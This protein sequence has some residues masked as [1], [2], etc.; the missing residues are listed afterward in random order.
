MTPEAHVVFQLAE[1]EAKSIIDWRSGWPDALAYVLGLAAAWFGG[2]QA[3][4]LIWSLWLSSLVIGYALIVWSI[5]QPIAVFSIIAWRSRND[6]GGPGLRDIVTF[7]S[8]M[9]GVGLFLVAFFTVHF[10]GFHYVY[11]AILINIFPIVAPGIPHPDWLEKATYLEIVRRYWIFLP[12]AFL[13]H[14][15]AFIR[16]TFLLD[17]NE[18]V[19]SWKEPGENNE[20]FKEPYKNVLRLHA[21]IGFVAAAHIAGLDNF[22]VYA[23]I[24]SVYFFPWRLVRSEGEAE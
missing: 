1:P 13:S 12:A 10:G 5:G 14:R 24:Y 6:P 20:M 22:A 15:A 16:R 18:P 4:D 11:S 8:V 17:G 9:I 3:G 2:W 23:V 19:K 7:C 21:L